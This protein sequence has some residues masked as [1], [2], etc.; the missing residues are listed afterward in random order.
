MIDFTGVTALRIPEGD[1]TKVIRKSDGVVLWEKVTSRLPKEFQEVEYIYIPDGAYINTGFIPADDTTFYIKLQPTRAYCFGT[2]QYP[3]LAMV[4]DT[5]SYLQVYNVSNGANGIL[6]Y[7]PPDGNVRDDVVEVRTYSCADYCQTWINNETNGGMGPD[8][9][10]YWDMSFI[11]PMYIGGWQ[12]NDTTF[13]TGELNAYAVRA[14][15]GSTQYLDLVP[16][17]RKSDNVAGMYNLV[18]GSFL[19]NSGSGTIMISPL[20]TLSLIWRPGHTCSYTVGQSYTPTANSGYTVSEAIAVEPGT[21]YK[22]TV[23][24]VAAEGSGFRFV[25]ADS[26]GIVTEAV[27]CGP[28]VGNNMFTFAPSNGTTQMRLRTYASNENWTWKLS[29]G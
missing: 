7:Y 19:T 6:G 2:G 27:S 22:V 9:G 17:Y 12:Y 24:A 3:R 16:C 20:L 25:G 11:Y 5:S 1:V 18:D 29:K 10:I 4:V 13:R 8:G 15:I 28:T 21:T 23:Q 14:Q 26:N